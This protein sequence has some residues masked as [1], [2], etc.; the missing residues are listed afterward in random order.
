VKNAKSKRILATRVRI[1]G[2][3]I[4]ARQIALHNSV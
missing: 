2:Q 4:E 3:V 1:E